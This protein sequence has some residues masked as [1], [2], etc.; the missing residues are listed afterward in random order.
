MAKPV[1]TKP[2]RPAPVDGA[3]SDVPSDTGSTSANGSGTPGKGAASRSPG[4]KSGSAP[5][6]RGKR[7][8]R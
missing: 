8:R 2:G 3:V 6:N 7:K 5:A 4:G 1:R